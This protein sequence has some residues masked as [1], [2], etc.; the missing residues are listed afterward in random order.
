MK[1]HKRILVL[2]W[3][4]ALAL[5]LLPTAALA[6]QQWPP[7]TLGGVAYYGDVS[8]CAMTSDQALAFAKLMRNKTQDLEKKTENWE[9]Y[10][11][12]PGTAHTYA[13]LFDLG[14]GRPALFFAGGVVTH[15]S[16]GDWTQNIRADGCTWD[17]AGEYGIWEYKNGQAV[18]LPSE[19]L[20]LTYCGSYVF[21]GGP[22]GSDGSRYRGKVYL[23][24]GGSIPSQAVT[25]GEYT[26]DYK[27]Y[28]M[29]YK[30]SVDGQSATEEQFEQ[31]KNAWDL[32]RNA[33]MG[34]RIEGGVGGDVWGMASALAT[35]DA[36]EAYARAKGMPATAS[37]QRVRIDG[38][39][40]G[41]R[42]YVLTDEAGGATTYVRLRDLASSLNETDASFAVGWDGQVTVETGKD[43]TPNGSEFSLPFEGDRCYEKN[44]AL[45]LVDGRAVELD[46]ITLKDDQG[47]GYTYYQLRDLGKALGFNVGWSAQE[48]I[49]LETD[50]PYSDKD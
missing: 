27:G 12:A 45:T 10:N 3:A 50:K 48:G 1:N 33:P 29:L 37:Q 24:G 20:E 40:R 18:K 23:L 14:G 47:N 17:N 46:S 34:H 42:T 38:E 30:Y 36:L 21:V 32:D 8:Q 49:F 5:A 39:D 7:A 35:A 11:N 43:Y 2:T 15:S 26:A 4:L 28:D 44:A 31:W 16:Y 41:F 9:R 6:E 25:T 22:I 13:A 19:G